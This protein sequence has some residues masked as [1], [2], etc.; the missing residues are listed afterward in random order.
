MVEIF[1]QN[2]KKLLRYRWFWTGDLAQTAG[3]TWQAS[4]CLGEGKRRLLFIRGIGSRLTH[5]L[6]GKACRQLCFLNSCIFKNNFLPISLLT[7]SSWYCMSACFDCSFLI[8]FYIYS[9]IR[10]ELVRLEIIYLGFQRCRRVIST[11]LI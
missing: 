9:R 3:R 2:K 11:C 8:L 5:W 4:S 6:P 1:Y 10:K 7:V